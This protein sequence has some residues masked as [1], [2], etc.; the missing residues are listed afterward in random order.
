MKT[1]NRTIVKKYIVKRRNEQYKRAAE[2]EK[3]KTISILTSGVIHDLNNVL[4]TITG[5]VDI[6]LSRDIDEKTKNEIMIVKKSAEDGAEIT[7]R[8][9]SYGT[10]DAGDKSIFDIND[11]I[12]YAVLI[13]KPIWHNQERLT[14]RDIQVKFTRMEPLLVLGNEKELRE[15]FVN[16]IINSIDAI[17][18][19]G[20]IE[21][22]LKKEDNRAVVNIIDNG[23]GIPE[24][25]KS[26]IF[27]P[28][29]STKKGRGSG[30]GLS[31]AYNTISSMGKN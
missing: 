8:I 23:H 16:M 18:E 2:I 14:G 24:S 20:A 5:Y 19:R 15:A 27:D 6:I 26:K 31:L 30:L 10:P 22:Y 9:K 3:L 7:K 29:F 11:S 17:K 1:K 25:I 13:T 21:I 12:E 4:T 28:F